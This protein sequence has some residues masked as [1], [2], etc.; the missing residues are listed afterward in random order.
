MAKEKDKV[1]NKEFMDK[2]EKLKSLSATLGQIEK[3]FGKGAIMRLGDKPAVQLDVIPTGA[4]SLDICLGIG[5]IP[6]G[7]VI[8]IYGPESSGKTTLAMTICAQAQKKGGI[9]AIVDAE[10]AMDPVYAKAIGVNTD[11]LLI[12]Q[13][14]TG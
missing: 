14:D 10:H 12:S 9:A 11:D 5:G 7:R 4:L 1:I 3:N 13:P 2:K 6:K 8:E